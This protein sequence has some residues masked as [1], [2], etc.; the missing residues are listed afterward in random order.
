MDK[1]HTEIM[2][3]YLLC[4]SHYLLSFNIITH[5]HLLSVGIPFLEKRL[6]VGYY[7]SYH[8]DLF[9][10]VNTTNKL[11]IQEYSTSWM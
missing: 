3:F 6:N 10:N 9:V 8:T 11:L 7:E 2:L 5:N 4:E 1:Y